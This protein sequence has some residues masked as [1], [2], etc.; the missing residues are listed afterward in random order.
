MSAEPKKKRDNP[1]ALGSLS[2]TEGAILISVVS[3]II[4]AGT[5]AAINWKT[6][7][8]IDL[9]S[10]AGQAYAI[11]VAKQNNALFGQLIAAAFVFLGIGGAVAINKNKGT[12]SSGSTGNTPPL[13]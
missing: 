12:G 5:N 13:D 10:P 1:N 3:L 6:V 8:S 11:E 7:D 4:L 9:N 2:K